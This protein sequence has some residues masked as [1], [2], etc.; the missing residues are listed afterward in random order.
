MHRLGIVTGCF[1]GMAFEDALAAV[2][3]LGC[4][5]IELPL[6]AHWH[7]ESLE[8]YLDDPAAMREL[9]AADGL[10]VIAAGGWTDFVQPIPAATDRQ[11]AKL[12]HFID[13]ASSLGCPTVR[14]LGGVP[15]PAIPEGQ[16]IP[17]VIEGL[18]QCIPHAEEDGVTL[19][20]ENHGT[21]CND[22]ESLR[23]IVSEVGSSRL[24]LTLDPSNFRWAGH[25][26]KVV[27]ETLRELAPLAG[28]VHLKNGD[29]RSGPRDHYVPTCL[30][31]GEMSLELFVRELHRARYRGDYAIDY[32]GGEEARAAM[33]RNLE[34]ARM[35]LAE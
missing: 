18:R 29:G 35:L 13:I 14:I 7:G 25:P 30:E 33:E 24:R 28:Y 6:N 17:L 15:K 3:S 31:D 5:Y 4:R 32:D 19:C 8:C 26:V 1:R 11:I 34:F 2:S 16:W 27:H 20:L 10:V 22:M 23:R 21:L 9:L 12:N